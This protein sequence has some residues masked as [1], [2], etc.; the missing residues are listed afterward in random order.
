VTLGV[1][2]EAGEALCYRRTRDREIEVERWGEQR[3]RAQD[4]G[5][6]RDGH[7]GWAARHAGR[8]RAFDRR[9]ERWEGASVAGKAWVVGGSE[10]RVRKRRGEVWR[11][12]SGQTGAHVE[13][14]SFFQNKHQLLHIT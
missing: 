9:S 6:V 2:K 5:V 4:G 12:A 11:V 13:A 7:G 8:I 14:L 10:Q 3:Q 1:G